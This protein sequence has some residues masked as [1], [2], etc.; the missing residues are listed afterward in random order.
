MQSIT[1][2]I[3]GAIMNIITNIVFWT[4]LTAIGTIGVAILA[5]W[6]I[7]KENWRK[8]WL[9]IDSSEITPTLSDP[10]DFSSPWVLCLILGITNKTNIDIGLQMAYVHL[11]YTSDKSNKEMYQ[12]RFGTGERHP[13]LFAK[14]YESNLYFFKFDTSIGQQLNSETLPADT[15]VEKIEIELWTTVRRYNLTVSKKNWPKMLSNLLGYK[16]PDAPEIE[17]KQVF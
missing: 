6:P 14:K 17:L 1:A 13:T 12:I 4:A 8:L 5:V 15:Q 2:V 3:F 11:Y 10:N 9:K 7:I 16:F